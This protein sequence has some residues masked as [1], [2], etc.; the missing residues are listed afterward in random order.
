MCMYA[1]GLCVHLLSLIEINQNTN[2]TAL[3]LHIAGILST[4]TLNPINR[5][6]MLFSKNVLQ[7]CT[8][9]NVKRLLS[10][11]QDSDN[12]SSFISSTLLCVPQKSGTNA[13]DL[14]FVG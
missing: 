1:C 3:L 6:G 11:A 12:L 10:K 14:L 4:N 8:F 2:Y 5:Q 7:K 13:F 9:E